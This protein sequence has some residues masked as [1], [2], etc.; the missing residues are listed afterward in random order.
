M[1]LSASTCA[2]EPKSGALHP[3]RAVLVVGVLDRNE[4]S[5]FERSVC[6]RMTWDL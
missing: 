4:R 1:M 2:Y 3:A 5:A 6:G